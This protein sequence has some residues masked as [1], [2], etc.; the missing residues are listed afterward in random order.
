MDKTIYSLCP[1]LEGTED[2]DA[3]CKPSG[4]VRTVELCA[5]TW[6]LWKCILCERKAQNA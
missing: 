4:L 3:L 1:S 5:Q 2:I 6:W